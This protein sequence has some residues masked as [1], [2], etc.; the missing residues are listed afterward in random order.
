MADFL[1]P[2]GDGWHLAQLNVGRPL[3][4]IEGPVMAEFVAQLGEINALAEASPG[5]VWRLIGDGGN[6]TDVRAEAD[7]QLLVNLSVWTSP[8]ALFDYVYKTAH[9]RV[10]ARRREWFERMEVFQVLWWIPAG[11]TPTVAEAMAR[12]ARLRDLGPSPDGFTFKQR[13]PAPG[14]L[15]GPTNMRPEPYC[16]S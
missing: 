7:P 11:H 15:G 10:M 9:T 3:G 13:Y 12:L 8:E 16:V 1:A 4:P 14:E 5:F 6:A 2:S